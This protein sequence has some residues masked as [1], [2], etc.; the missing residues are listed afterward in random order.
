MRCAI[1]VGPSFK[2]AQ[3]QLLQAL[4]HCDLAE[5]RLDLWEDYQL[6]ELRTLHFPKPLI[7]TLK[8]ELSK[9]TQLAALKPAYIDLEQDVPETIFKELRA[10]FPKVKLIAS[11]H[12]FDKTPD[13][14]QESSL[15]VDFYKIATMTH[16]TLDALRL[17]IFSQNAKQP[18]IISGMGDSGQITRILG[19]VY[20]SAWSYA[21]LENSQMTAPGQILLQELKTYSPSTSVYG[22]IGDPVDKSF[23]HIL[24]NG[25]MQLFNAPSVY[26][27]MRI[28]SEELPHFIPLMKKLNMRGL[29]VTMPL[30]VAI[31][32]YLDIK[33]E[34]VQ[35][36]GACNTLL[37]DGKAL[38]GY[39]TDSLGALNA[40]E[41]GLTLAGKRLLIIGAGGAAR[42]IAWEAIQ[43]KMLV[44]IANRNADRA[45]FISRLFNCSGIGLDEVPGIDYDAIINATPAEMPIS[46][47]WL[48]PGTVAMDIRNR[49]EKTPFLKAAVE[50]GCIPV[51]G[52]RMYLHQAAGQIDIWNYAG[53]KLPSKAVWEG[54]ASIDKSFAR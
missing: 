24:H 37:W 13:T 53:C 49:K 25:M 22:L 21:P 16:S 11:F 1:I 2:Q 40:L 42:A 6:E 48:I 45:Q 14:L 28:T 8:K 26:V 27:K 39:N 47:E 32:P 19:P 23:G 30:K 7:F 36:C 38:H 41:E 29:S 46:A 12:D 44:T 10:K 5:L 33:D 3:E 35:K 34:T 18:L 54:F 52:L 31:L 9:L 20:K 15:P 17:L 50:R 51:S 43:R 4:P